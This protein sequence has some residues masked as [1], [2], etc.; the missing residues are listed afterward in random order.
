MAKSAVDH[1]GRFSL[2]MAIRSPLWMP[3]C[4]SARTVPA[5]LR[6]R[7]E[8]EMGSHFPGFPVE[9]GSVEI[10]LGGGEENV[11]QRGESHWGSERL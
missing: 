7:S 2:S 3:H 9:H 8:E 5:T 4:W 1:S 10:A 6:R 11:V